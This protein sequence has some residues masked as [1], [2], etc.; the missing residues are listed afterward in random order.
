MTQFGSLAG[1]SWIEK[2]VRAS[3]GCRVVN[4][5]PLESHGCA[6]TWLER[7]SRQRRKT[8]VSRWSLPQNTTLSAC[9]FLQI[10]LCCIEGENSLSLS[11]FL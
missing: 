5:K 2:F 3:D 8:L 1:Q 9:Y 7:G 6:L 10:Q 11:L 4:N